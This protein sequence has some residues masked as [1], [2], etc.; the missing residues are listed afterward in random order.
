MNNY[1]KIE[2]ATWP[3]A[4][5]WEYYRTIVKANVA[6]TKKIDVTPVVEFCKQENRHFSPVMLHV[7][8]KTVNSLD[9]MKMFADQQG[10]PCLWEEIHP[11][12]TVFHKD[13]ETFSDIWMEYYPDLEMF[14]ENYQKILAQYGD[15]KGI[16]VRE[17]QPP[18]FFPVSCVPW[19]S[20]DSVTTQTVGSTMAPLFPIID[21]GKY[22]LDH[23]KYRMPV[24]I[25][26]SHAAMDGFHLAKFFEILQRNADAMKPE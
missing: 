1:K 11:N 13:D 8:C 22:E 5:H 4:S 2:L 7:I 10:N 19:I 25:S 26:I 15:K 20:F 17:N 12:F 18:N 3:R 6:M 24:S 23:G 14:E 21:Y 16:K 9:C